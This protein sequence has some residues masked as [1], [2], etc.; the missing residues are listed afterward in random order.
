MRPR[1]WLQM[2]AQ[3]IATRGS[4][5]HST[6]TT[7]KRREQCRS[8]I[9]ILR[10]GCHHD[11]N[12]A[13]RVL[14]RADRGR[15]HRDNNINFQLHQ[16]GR[17]VWQAF[18]AALGKAPFDN[19]VLTFAL[20]SACLTLP[21]P[22]CTLPSTCFAAPFACWVLLPVSSPAFCWILPATSLAAPF[23]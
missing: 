6:S 5:E 23:T 2:R 10:G 1:S 7:A 12:R 16:V 3:S 18:E 22:F 9:W 21:T 17:Q 11:G 14:G 20:S 8:N 13:G 4:V 19:E 15:C